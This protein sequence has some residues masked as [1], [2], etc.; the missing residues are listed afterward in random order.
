MLFTY[1]C[2]LY[3]SIFYIIKYPPSDRHELLSILYDDD[4][5]S[6]GEGRRP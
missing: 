5:D 3:Y 4:G 6:D 1:Y 2:C